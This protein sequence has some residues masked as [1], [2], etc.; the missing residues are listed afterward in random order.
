MGEIYTTGYWTPRAGEEDAFVEAW[1]EFARWAS[2]MPG[3]GTLRLARHEGDPTRFVSFGRWDSLESAHAWKA[4]PE[5]GERMSR[6]QRHVEQ[7]VPAEL[8]VVA[9][10]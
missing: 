3:A 6:V 1:L 7:F 5:F 2:Q 8:S 10:A 4:S 9:T